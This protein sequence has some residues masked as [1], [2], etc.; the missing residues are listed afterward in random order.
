MKWTI[1][2]ILFACIEAEKPKNY[3]SLPKEKVFHYVGDYTK[4]VL[5]IKVITITIDKC[6]YLISTQENWAVHKGNCKNHLK[7]NK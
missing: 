3:D 6:E 1:L 4:R 7:E 2:L 5:E